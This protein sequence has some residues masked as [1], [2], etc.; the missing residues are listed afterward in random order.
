[1]TKGF[2][3]NALKTRASLIAL[4]ALLSACAQPATET[5]GMLDTQRVAY[6][7]GAPAPVRVLPVTAETV[8]LIAAP[9][10]TL[11]GGYEYRLGL[12]DVVQ[13]FAT[14]AP[15]LTIQTGYRVQ[16]DGMIQV[17]YLGRVAANGRSTAQLRAD[18]A[19][20]LRPYIARPQVEVRITAFNA[21]HVSVVG[22]VRQPNRQALTESPLTVIDAINAAGGFATDAAQTNVTL[23]RNGVPQGVDMAG[24][25][26]HG[27]P[28]PVLLEGDVLRVERGASHVASRMA[29]TPEQV[30]Q[31][32]RLVTP[33]GQ[34]LAV[35]LAGVAVSVAQVAPSLPAGNVVL[36]RRD[37]AGIT[38]HSFAGQDSI[39]PEIG[40]QVMLAPGDVL[41]VTPPTTNND[42][43]IA[44]LSHALIHFIQ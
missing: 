19:Q 42:I 35:S 5:P 11:S 37:H 38:A 27:Q 12:G 32:A 34:T 4:A 23:I 8:G 33:D 41:T 44:N 16:G 17:P 28:L 31:I 9:D 43:L 20:R 30:A 25:L 7:A 24:F 1:M 10:M 13:I 18:I 22:A 14:D 39:A 40:G 26:T 21:R 6:G 29:T 2:A 36:L 15:E 3:M